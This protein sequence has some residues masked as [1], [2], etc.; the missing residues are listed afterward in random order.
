[1]QQYIPI[2]SLGAGS[3]GEAILCKTQNR[4]LVVIKKIKI[5]Y[6]HRRAL[7]NELKILQQLNHPN[8]IR[9]I[10]Y[11]YSTQ[12]LNLVLEYAD[13]GNLESQIKARKTPF[14]VNLILKMTFQ[15]LSALKQLHAQNVIHRDVK[16]ENILLQKNV[17]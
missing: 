6:E 2:Q 12:H 11:F 13:Y 3:Q 9:L 5:D 15:M 7:E 16:P 17:S 14:P 8:L 10:N 1:M 4:E